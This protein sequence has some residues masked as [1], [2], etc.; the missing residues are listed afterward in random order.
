MANVGDYSTSSDYDEKL[1]DLL[2]LH[3][4]FS[5]ISDKKKHCLVKGDASETI[6]PW[7]NENPHAIVSMAIF[8][9]DLYKPTKNVLE[10]I[11]PRLVKGSLL[12]FDE[13]NC[14]FFPGETLALEGVRIK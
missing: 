5:P 3:E 14:E 8:D 1:T 13:L 12:V 4:S 2:N 9:M 11:I 10:K 7:L 6:V